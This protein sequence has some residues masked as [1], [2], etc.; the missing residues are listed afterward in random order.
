MAQSTTINIVNTETNKLRPWTYVAKDIIAALNAAELAAT[1]T[2]DAT[3]LG[4]LKLSPQIRPRR[5]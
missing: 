4:V 3:N 5:I 1:T 2:G